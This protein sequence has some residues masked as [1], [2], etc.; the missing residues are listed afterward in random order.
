MTLALAP[1]ELLKIAKEANVFKIMGESRKRSVTI[2]YVPARSAILFP[3]LEDDGPLEACPPHIET[4]KFELDS[5][6]FDL[7]G[8]M[9]YVALVCRG[10]IIVNP[11]P[12]ET[13]EKL[14]TLKI[15]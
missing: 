14:A 13:F 9:T 15:G 12:W 10:M 8:G 5:A 7:A 3:R 2:D 1:E 11:F 4:L 6:V